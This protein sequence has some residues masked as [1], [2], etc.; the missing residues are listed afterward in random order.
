MG[1]VLPYASRNTPPLPRPMKIRP[2]R[3]GD[4]FWRKRRFWIWVFVGVVFAAGAII[5]MMPDRMALP[6]FHI[7]RPNPD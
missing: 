5:L 4:P 3:Y 2:L 6:P 7:M 1:G